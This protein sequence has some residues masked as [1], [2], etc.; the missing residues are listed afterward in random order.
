MGGLGVSDNPH[1]HN[2]NWVT[3][4]NDFW[5][6]ILWYRQLILTLRKHLYAISTRSGIKPPFVKIRNRSR[7][8]R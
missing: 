1:V 8:I 4:R 3:T 7:R 2:F 6:A 5:L